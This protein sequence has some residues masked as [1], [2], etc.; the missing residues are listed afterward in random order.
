[1]GSALHRAIRVGKHGDRPVDPSSLKKKSPKS[2]V[3]TS[4]PGNADAA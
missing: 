2:P 1:M 4:L 3:L